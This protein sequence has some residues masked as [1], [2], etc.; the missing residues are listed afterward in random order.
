[1]SSLMEIE[2]SQRFT[3]ADVLEWD[4]GERYELFDGA[5]YMMAPPSRMHQ[6]LLMD[7]SARI[8]DFLKGKPCKVFPTPFGVR[9]FPKADN[10]DD[11]FFE[12]DIVVVCDSSKLDDRGCNGAPDLVVEILS[13]STMKNDLLYQ[14]NKYLA[15]GVREYWI[16]DPDE[17]TISVNVLGNGQFELTEYDIEAELASAALQ[18][19]ALK[20]KDIFVM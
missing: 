20:V 6:E 12:P 9:L 14:L 16:V 1:M 3:Y 10:S 8:H 19:F 18:G 4:E 5:V 7:I 17:K 2:D 11:T 13:P 15:A